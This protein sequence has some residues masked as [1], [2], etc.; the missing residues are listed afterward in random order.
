MIFECD[1]SVDDGDK[2][3]RILYD[4]MVTSR[5]NHIC[6]EC[7]QAIPKGHK[8]H[9]LTARWDL[10]WETYRTCIPCNAIR[11]RYC[12]NGFILSTLRET[13]LECLGFDY[14]NVPEEDEEA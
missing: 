6:C 2:P 12:P 13:L 9:L 3:T 7:G 14:T 10:G 5:Q 8:H 11:E 4:R 1:C